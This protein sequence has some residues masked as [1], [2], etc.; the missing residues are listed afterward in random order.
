MIITNLLLID[1]KPSE[2][3]CENQGWKKNI[4]HTEYQLE[5]IR[6]LPEPI[7]E[8]KRKGTRCQVKLYTTLEQ[9]KKAKYLSDIKTINQLNMAEKKKNR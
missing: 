7:I 6:K 2:T 8:R 5:E 1:K 3:F 4:Y 9:I